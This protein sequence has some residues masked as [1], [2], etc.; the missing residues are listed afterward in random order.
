MA[1]TCAPRVME[2]YHPAVM[3]EERGTPAAASR[4]TGGVFD[5]RERACWVAFNRTPG[6]AAKR[7]RLLLDRFGSL[8]AAWAAPGREL[9]LAGL[10]QRTMAALE[11]TRART[12]PEREL[13]RVRR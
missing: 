2:R 13:A 4:Q 6:I 12:D 8:A 10:D 9:A 11:A 5:D 7:V 3:G 1:R